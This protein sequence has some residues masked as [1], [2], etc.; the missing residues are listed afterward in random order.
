MSSDVRE[1]ARECLAAII[2]GIDTSSSS[3]S[4]DALEFVIDGYR[5]NSGSLTGPIRRSV[6]VECERRGW[7][8]VWKRDLRF[9][10]WLAVEDVNKWPTI[11]SRT[12]KTA[13]ECALLALKWLLENPSE[14]S[15]GKA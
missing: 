6:E 14:V 1:L 3:A 7:G 15:D 4:C 13:L 11:A 10:Y 9:S 12:G 8:C 5:C 2:E